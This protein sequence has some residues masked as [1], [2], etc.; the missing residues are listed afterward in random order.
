[1]VEVAEVVDIN[2]LAVLVSA[3]AMFVLGAVWYSPPLFAKQWQALTKLK[4]KDLKAN[5]AVSYI[6]S[7]LCYLIMAYALAY[8]VGQ[9]GVDGAADG[10][11]LGGL[12]GFGFAVPLTLSNALFHNTRKKLWMINTAY[13]VLGLILMGVILGVWK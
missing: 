2:L 4:E 5:M 11:I 12:V 7:F 3:V 13:A 1:M 9:L 8:F 6:G 10:A